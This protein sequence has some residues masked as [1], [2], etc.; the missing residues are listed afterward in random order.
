MCV[1]VC[2]CV[3]VAARTLHRDLPCAMH[4][5]DPGLFRRKGRVLLR[6]PRVL[7]A[8]AEMAGVLGG[9]DLPAAADWPRHSQEHEYGE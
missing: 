2:V 1:C 8:G 5:I 9:N 4:F 7:L 6:V 3:C